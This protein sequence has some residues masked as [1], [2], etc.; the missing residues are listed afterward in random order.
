MFS[1]H[2]APRFFPASLLLCIAIGRFAFI[3]G[4]EWV[5]NYAQA[6][7]PDFDQFV[8]PQKAFSDLTIQVL[9]TELVKDD[10]KTL[11]VRMI[12]KEGVSDFGPAYLFDEGS[13]IDWT[14]CGRKLR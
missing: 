3:M 8:A 10:S 9:P 1:V 5:G 13:T 2:V 7:K 4:W 12:Q 14:P 6:R 11:R